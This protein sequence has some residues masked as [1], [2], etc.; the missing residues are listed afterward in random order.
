MSP[1]LAGELFTTSATWEAP[2]IIREIKIKTAMRYH[3]TLLRM[4]VITK[5]TNNKYWKGCG[6]VWVCT[7]LGENVNW[8]SHYGK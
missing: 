1:V 4:A 5:F 6:R 3:L 8:Y 2:L 7:L